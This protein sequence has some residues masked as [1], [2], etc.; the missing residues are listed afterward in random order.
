MVRV[1]RLDFVVQLIFNS[2][3]YVVHFLLLEEHLST[4]YVPTN[5][6]QVFGQKKDRYEKKLSSPIEVNSLVFLHLIIYSDLYIT[7]HM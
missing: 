6:A 2:K 7:T 4:Y 3:R 1:S 5:T